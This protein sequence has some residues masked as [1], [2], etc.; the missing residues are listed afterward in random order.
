MLA[1]RVLPL[2]LA[3]LLAGCS[4]AIKQRIAACKVGDW[5]QIGKTDGLE[6][7]PPNFADRKDFCEDHDDGGKSATA[8]AGA[9]YTLGWEQGNAQ[10]W[11]ALGMADGARGQ[12]QQFAARAAGEEV[13]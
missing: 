4:A 1:H 7:A 2:I 11:T 3:V 5:Q 10:M 12:P 9:R 13:R 8:D 6:G